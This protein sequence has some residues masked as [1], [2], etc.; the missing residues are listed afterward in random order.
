MRCAGSCCQ[1]PFPPCPE[2]TLSAYLPRSMFRLMF[3]FREMSMSTLPWPQL[4]C[5]HA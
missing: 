5:P 4:Q 1:D 3:V 2:E